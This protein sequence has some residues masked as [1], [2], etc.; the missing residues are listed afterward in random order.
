VRLEDVEDVNKSRSYLIYT[1]AM[2]EKEKL[3][4]ARLEIAQLYIHCGADVNIVRGWNGEGALMITIRFNNLVVAELLVG[5]GADVCY[6]PPDGGLIALH[7]CVSLAATRQNSDTLKMMGLL[8][9]QGAN[10]NQACRFGGSPLHNLLVEAW[11]K[12]EQLAQINKFADLARLLID[13]G[14]LMPKIFGKDLST[15]T[16]S[17]R[18]CKQKTC[19]ILRCNHS[20]DRDVGGLS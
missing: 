11:Y 18:H 17:T 1:L 6:A 10:P 19:I 3:S 16:H 15:I 14:A 13:R 12:R 9:K 4:I 7:K 20:L 8:L 5:N 2:S